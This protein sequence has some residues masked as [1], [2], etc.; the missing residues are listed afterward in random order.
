MKQYQVCDI[1][2][3]KG[4]SRDESKEKTRDWSRKEMEAR[5]AN[6]HLNYDCAKNV[7]DVAGDRPVLFIST[8]DVFGFYDG[9][10]PVNGETP[11]HPVSKYARSKAMAEEET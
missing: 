7:F 2:S 11:I 9:K 5:M 3:S 6:K 10:K 4:D 1:K 8:V